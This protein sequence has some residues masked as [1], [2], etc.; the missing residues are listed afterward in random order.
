MAEEPGRFEKATKHEWDQAPPPQPP[1]K[2]S[3]WLPLLHEVKSGQIVKIP[4]ADEAKLKGLRIGLAR[5]ASS[6]QMKLEFRILHGN[7]LVKQ[8]E[9]PYQPPEP[10]PPTSTAAFRA[11]ALNDQRSHARTYGRPESSAAFAPDGAHRQEAWHAQQ[12]LRC[13]AVSWH[14]RRPL[15]VAVGG[16]RLADIEQMQGMGWRRQQVRPNHGRVHGQGGQTSEGMPRK[17]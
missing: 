10:K 15:L 8:S 6:Q 11:A 14:A 4:V 2:E 5:L 1:K 7:L 12:R 17:R 13:S 3:P 16:A 9:S